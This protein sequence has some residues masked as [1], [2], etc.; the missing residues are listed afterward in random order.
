M[1][2]RRIKIK[3][4]FPIKGYSRLGSYEQQLPLTSPLMLNCRIKDVAENKVRGGQRPALIKAYTTQVGGSYP[5][6]KMAAITTI[7]IEP[8]S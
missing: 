8:A 7:S 4:Y 5:I 2:L 6:I 3:F 1:V